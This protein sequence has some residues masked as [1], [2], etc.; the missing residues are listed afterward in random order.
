MEGEGRTEDGGEGGTGDDDEVEEF[1][2]RVIVLYCAG[3]RGFRCVVRCSLLSAALCA[4]Y[5]LLSLCAGV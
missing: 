2:A 3:R 5:V 1:S 4:G